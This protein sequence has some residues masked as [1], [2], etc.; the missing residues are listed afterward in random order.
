MIGI[1]RPQRYISQGM[2]V[3]DSN[4]KVV[5]IQV[6]S[7]HKDLDGLHIVAYL[8]ERS[9]DDGTGEGGMNDGYIK[10]VNINRW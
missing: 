4:L 3:L 7:F 6:I 5:M 2:A 10:S 8:D 1:G 9:M